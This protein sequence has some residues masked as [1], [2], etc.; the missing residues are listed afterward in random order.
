MT[1]DLEVKVDS[2]SKGTDKGTRK[3]FS[4]IVK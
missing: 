2:E 1:T 3:L 4:D